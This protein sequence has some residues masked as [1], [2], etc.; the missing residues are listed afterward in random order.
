MSTNTTKNLSLHAWEPFDPFTREEFNENF[1]KLDA[2]AGVSRAGIAAAQSAADTAQ[3][4]ADTAQ[5]T[6]NTARS[7]AQKAQSTVDNLAQTVANNKSQT[8]AAKSSTDAALAALQTAVG[9]HGKTARIVYGTMTSPSS[10]AFSLSFDFKPMVVFLIM[11][12]DNGSAA[13]YRDH[14]TFPGTWSSM[15]WTD[16]G[17]TISEA[18]PGYYSKTLSY[19]AIGEER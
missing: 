1:E 10:G 4:A 17:V 14:N 18:L 7:E 9:T 15:T 3:S 19:I 16:N 13:L 5:S 11:Q 6:A 2:E 12:T 8:D